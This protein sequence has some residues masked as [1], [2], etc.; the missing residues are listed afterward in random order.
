M[1]VNRA[2]L[3]MISF[4]AAIGGLLFGFNIAIINGALVFLKKQ[5]ALTDFQTE[6]AVS[7]LLVGC[8]IGAGLVGTL[9]DRLGRK[10]MLLASA[11]IFAVSAVAAA[12][13]RDLVEFTIARFACGLAIGVASVLSPLYIAEMSPAE[14]RGRLVSI[15]QLA[16]VTGILSAY[17]VSWML[18][19]LGPSSWR[20]MFATAALPSVLFLLALLRVPESPRWLAKEGRNDEAMGVLSRISSFRDAQAEMEV[21]KK[22]IAEESGAMSQLLEPGLRKPLIIAVALAVLGQV[23]GVN[24]IL[25]YG[26]L[27]FTEQVGNQT[28]SAALLAN[29]IIGATNFIFTIV[30]LAIIDKI[31]RKALLMLSSGGMAAS[32]ILLGTLFR[33]DPTAIYAILG[34]ILGYVAFFAVGVGPGVWVVM[35]E[36][37]PT[38]IRGRAMAVATVTLWVACTALTLTFLSLVNA[39]TVSGAFWLYASL[40]VVTFVFVWRCV[41]ETKG[42]TLEEIEKIWR[43]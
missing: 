16:I 36:L 35:S 7:S 6:I 32:L 26:S 18:S 4:V 39:I 28:A 27:I 5:F 8:M 33:V 41:P 42:K 19:G 43:R 38:R 9:S 29:V 1:P 37:F 21:I 24:T 2:Y 34:V 23:T 3:Y 30:A 20:W 40:C 13:P 17:Y 11:A 10:K 31:G 25:F 12:I 22:T 15:N 14:I